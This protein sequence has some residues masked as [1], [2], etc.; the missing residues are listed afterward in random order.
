[1][2]YRKGVESSRLGRWEEAIEHLKKAVV[3]APRF[4][5]AHVNLALLYHGNNWFEEAEEEYLVALSLSRQHPQPFINLGG[6]YL[7]Q[8]RNKEAIGILRDAIRITP[9]PPAAFNNLGIA[10]FRTNQLEEA[11]RMLLRARDL[12]P[13][14]SSARLMLAN[15]YPDGRGRAALGTTRCVSS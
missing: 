11:E 4:F 9:P 2:H 6:L 14:Q 15:V 10:L 8:G 5:D 1:M 12:D 3:L 7:K 13:E